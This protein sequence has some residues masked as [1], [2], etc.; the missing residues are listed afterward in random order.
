MIWGGK[1]IEYGYRFGRKDVWVGSKSQ[2]E[3]AIKRMNKNAKG[4]DRAKLIQRTVPKKH[5]AKLK[6]ADKCSG[7]KCKGPYTCRKHAKSISGS[8]F[9]L[10]D[11]Q[12]RNK[13]TKRWDE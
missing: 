5:K 13:N 8:E 6:Q 7:G 12:G 1:E 11:R 3:S 9:E 4:G 10:Y 2:A